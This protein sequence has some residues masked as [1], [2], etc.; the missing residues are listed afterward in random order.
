MRTIEIYDYDYKVL[1]EI[2]EVN[3]IEIHSVVSN[4]CEYIDDMCKTKS[5]FSNKEHK[6]MFDLIERIKGLDWA[7]ETEEYGYVLSNFS[8]AGQDFNIVI[9][10][11]EDTE[12]FLDELHDAY[13]N[14]DISYEAYVRLD[15][16][17][18]GKNG[19]PY[20]MKDVYEDMEWCK[21]AIYDLWDAL[22]KEFVE[23]LEPES[24]QAI[25]HNEY[26]HLFPTVAEIEKDYNELYELIKDIKTLGQALD[27]YR[28]HKGVEVT[29]NGYDILNLITRD[30]K[31]KIGT[32]S[33]SKYGCLENVFMYFDGS[34]IEFNVSPKFNT[35]FPFIENAGIEEVSNMT[36]DGYEELIMGYIKEHADVV[37]EGANE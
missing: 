32:I 14:Y 17:G 11:P 19:A 16:Y 30:K 25:D 15:G 21:Q 4:L 24:E 1:A 29:V 7:V 27:F 34:D 3:D 20:D 33:F 10:D 18:H 9:T 6:T 13:A 5:L 22:R 8:P 12:D 23:E 37:I 36:D 26:R 35:V 31:T 28:E 2:A